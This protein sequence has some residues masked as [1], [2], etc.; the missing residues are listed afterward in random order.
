MEVNGKYVLAVDCGGTFLKAA[1]VDQDGNI[2]ER[3]SLPTTKLEVGAF[4]SNFQKLIQDYHDKISAVGIAFAGPVNPIKGLI[5][6]PPNFPKDFHNLPLSDIL[7]ERCNLPVALEN[8]ANLAALGEYWKG[9]NFGAQ[10]IIVITM[11]TGVGSGII[12]GGK[13]WNGTTGVAGEVGHIPLYE[14]GPICG[15]GNIACLETFASST[16]VVRMAKECIA[17]GDIIELSGKSDITAKDVYDLGIQGHPIAKQIF[18]KVGIAMGRGIV[19]IVHVMGI[20]KIIVTGGGMGAWELFAPFMKATYQK[21][22]FCQERDTVEVLPSTLQGNS[23]VLGAA[24]LAWEK[25]GKSP[26][27][28]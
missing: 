22:L 16:A 28:V 27:R 7:E 18:E 5:G 6:E 15:C 12:I 3:K 24:Y 9:S 4:I 14:R 10:P 11:G 23:G 13:I 21:M 26:K 2:C 1:L 25:I 20:A 17:S 19:V 8:D